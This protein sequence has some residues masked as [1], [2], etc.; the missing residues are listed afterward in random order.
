MRGRACREVARLAHGLHE[1]SR[2]RPFTFV[3]GTR[4]DACGLSAGKS[5][6]SQPSSPL[7][8]L[9]WP[10]PSSRSPRTR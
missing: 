2:L 8:G 5:L 3:V 4:L 9:R 10:P 7:S 1:R 6:R